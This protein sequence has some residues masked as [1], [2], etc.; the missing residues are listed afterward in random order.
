MGLTS[1]FSVTLSILQAL[2]QALKILFI[3]ANSADTDEMPHYAAFHLGLCCLPKYPF[4][5]SS[6]QRVNKG[7]HCT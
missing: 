2:K 3:I 6:I 1:N 5:I 7:Q 4:G